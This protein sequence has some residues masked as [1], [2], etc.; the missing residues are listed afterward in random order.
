MWS[1]L[2][3]QGRTDGIPTQTSEPGSAFL[4]PSV[5]VLE[6]SPPA[7]NVCF[8]DSLIGSHFSLS[9]S[10]PGD[11]L[12]ETLVLKE[13]SINMKTAHVRSETKDSIRRIPGSICLQRAHCYTVHQHDTGQPQCSGPPHCHLHSCIA[14]YKC[15]SLK[16]KNRYSDLRAQHF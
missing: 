2:I 11:W 6:R 8:V 3:T 14:T 10:P 5:R 1:V 16:T 15:A 12:L 4:S 13:M 7:E 9:F